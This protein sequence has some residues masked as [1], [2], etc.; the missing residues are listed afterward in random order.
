MSAILVKDVRKKL[1]RVGYAEVSLFLIK[2]WLLFGFI[3]I[4]CSRCEM[5]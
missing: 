4:F 1:V 2:R 3:P 5:G